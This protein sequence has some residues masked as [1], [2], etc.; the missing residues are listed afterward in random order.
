MNS[1]TDIY[2]MSLALDLAE[3]G[4][5][6]VSPNPMVGAIVVRDGEIVGKGYHKKAGS[7]HAE[8]I[9]LKHAADK[10]Y[11]ATLYVNIEPCCHFGK[12]P[13]C[14]DAIIKSGIIRVVSSMVDINPLV[15]GEGF[16]RLHQN[17]IEIVVGILDNRAKKLNESYIKFIQSKI[18]FLTL[19]L[20]ITL[21]G[22]IAAPD[23][24]SKWITGKKTRKRIHQLRSWS[25]AV[26]I[27]VN[28]VLAD[29]PM[30]T[31]YDI[32]GSNPLR[33]II[34]SRLRTPE[35]AKVLSDKNVVIA[36]TNKADEKKR[37][38]FSQR[39]IEVLKFD[40]KNGHVPLYEVLIKLGEKNITSLLCEGGSILASSLLKEKLID[41]II[42]TI[43]P[44]ILGGG[45]DAVKGLDIK[46]L[47][48][49]IRL[50]DIEVET[51][52]DDVVITGYPEYS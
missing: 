11:G 48:E 32:K 14:T 36:T 4:R 52:N 51:I 44:K 26:L 31:I 3:K 15:N 49:A 20:A 23:G 40:S 22:K 12:T 8:I 28:T 34:D 25:D 21:D 10:S 45:Y 13:P 41:K 5:G 35:N 18:P 29:D 38:L 27:G 50:K 9:A 7:D 46:S 16:K 33:V 39:C 47:D 1:N 2:F 42:F 43:A 17:N 30:L 19:K 6:L 24:K 37:S